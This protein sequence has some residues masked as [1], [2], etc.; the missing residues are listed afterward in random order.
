M[1]NCKPVSTPMV[2]G[3]EK[4]NLKNNL[5]VEYFPYGEVIGSLLYIAMGSK[6][7]IAFSINLLSRYQL[8]FTASD[9]EK[10]TNFEIFKRK[11]GIVY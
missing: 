11:Y 1:E 10:Q 2:L 7:D 6:P 5:S 8:N 4:L 3:P 9:V